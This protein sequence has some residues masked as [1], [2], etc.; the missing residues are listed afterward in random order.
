MAGKMPNPLQ[1]LRFLD[2][3][4]GETSDEKAGLHDVIADPRDTA[5]ILVDIPFGLGH[6]ANIIIGG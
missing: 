6:W 4:D 5:V 1:M 2:H 3:A